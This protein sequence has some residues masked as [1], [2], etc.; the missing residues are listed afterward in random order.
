MTKNKQTN[1]AGQ[2]RHYLANLP[3]PTQYA[4][5]MA[6][7]NIA[8]M[9]RLTQ[10]LE[11]MMHDDHAQN[12]PMIAAMVISKQGPLPAQGFFDKARDLGFDISDPQAFHSAQV[13]ALRK[14]FHTQPLFFYVLKP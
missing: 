3:C 11:Q 12:R 9:A 14:S 6:A 10:T 4:K 5:V 2:L 1:L 13:M 8:P 7:L